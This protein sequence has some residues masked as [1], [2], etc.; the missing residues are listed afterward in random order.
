MSTLFSHYHKT[1]QHG[2]IYSNQ[3]DRMSYVR[4]GLD[5]FPAPLSTTPHSNVIRCYVSASL[6]NT[7]CTAEIC[8]LVL[9]HAAGTSSIQKCTSSS[10]LI[11][12]QQIFSKPA[13]LV[14]LGLLYIRSDIDPDSFWVHLSSWTHALRKV[15]SF[16]ACALHS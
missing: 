2:F 16:V 14:I 7:C 3:C 13:S 6:V 9:C 10:C 1:L 12:K 15:S 11:T 8:F 4:K 5:L